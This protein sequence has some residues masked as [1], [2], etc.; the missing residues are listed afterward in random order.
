MS[1]V[2]TTTSRPRTRSTSTSVRYSSESTSEVITSAGVPMRNR[3]STRYSTRSTNG[4]IGLISWV[5]N[6][7]AVSWLRL[8]LSISSAT[9]R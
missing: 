7:T 9:S 2:P 1:P 5:T 6:R 3:P 8:R 4:R